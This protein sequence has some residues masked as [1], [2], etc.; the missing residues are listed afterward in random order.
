MDLTFLFVILGFFITA[1]ILITVIK[2]KIVA[3]QPKSNKPEPTTIEHRKKTHLT[4]ENERKFFYALKKA[5]NPK[6][7]VHCQVPLISVVA[8]VDYRN[9]SKSW[10]KRLD[11][12]ITDTATKI[13][14]AVELDDSTHTRKKVIKR[15]AYVASALSGHYPLV[16]F[17]TEN[18]YDPAK[19]AITLESKA[20]IPNHLATESEIT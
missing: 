1:S 4:T 6:Y 18:F 10:A 3:N 14:A 15:D 9:N 12:V 13:V 16:R 20:G 8:P 11:F 19:L 17:D 7:M 5:L 2:S